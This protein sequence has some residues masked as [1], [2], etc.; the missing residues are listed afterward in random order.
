MSPLDRRSLLLAFSG[1]MLATACRTVQGSKLHQG[2][3]SSPAP[4]VRRRWVPG[5]TAEY[6]TKYIKAVTL[7]KANDKKFKPKD[8]GY[9]LSWAGLVAVHEKSCQHK[10]WY[11]LPYHRLYLLYFEAACQAVLEDPTFAIPYWD[12]SMDGTIPDEFYDTEALQAPRDLVKGAAIP[13]GFVSKTVVESI[14]ASS[15]FHNFHSYEPTF[16]LL[17]RSTK[18]EG[19]FEMLPHDGVHNNI[20]GIMA[21]ATR[22]PTDPI[23]WLHHANIDRLWSIWIANHAE[24]ILPQLSLT[25]R[26]KSA[27]PLKALAWGDMTIGL[28]MTSPKPI[29]LEQY[30]DKW[31]DVLRTAGAQAGIP[32]DDQQLAGIGFLLVPN[33]AKPLPAGPFNRA[34]APTMLVKD[35]IAAEKMPFF[36]DTDMHMSQAGKTLAVL[37]TSTK[38]GSNKGRTETLLTGKT[39]VTG[40]RLATVVTLDAKMLADLPELLGKPA[41][42]SVSLTF[43]NLRMPADEALRRGLIV[44]YFIV[45]PEKLDLIPKTLT[46]TSFKLPEYVGAQSFFLTNHDHGSGV[47]Q[48]KDPNQIS[49]AIDIS[50]WLTS[51]IKANGSPTQLVLVAV[52]AN[53]K[54]DYEAVSI[55]AA[56]D[57]SELGLSVIK[58]E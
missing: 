47:G 32:I 18:E 26:D 10:N 56:A 20:G 12:W 48:H 30:K 3:G 19:Q 53:T 14:L 45:S 54:K 38:D 8:V 5:E 55:F 41:A 23:F 13:E 15:E 57:K 7:L 37:E 34:A 50:A 31:T 1:S 49:G 9:Y 52:A 25:E 17:G 22:S 6:K 42:N 28:D 35:L 27:D 33:S 21:N 58:S 46:S 4:V 2:A 44:N 16:S 43:S 36:Y 51:Y 40:N 39:T 11:L 29:G 24:S